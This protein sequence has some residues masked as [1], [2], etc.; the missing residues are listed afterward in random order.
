MMLRYSLDMEAEAAAVEAAVEAVLS[1]GH[2]TRDLAKPGEKALD[3]AEM[4]ALIVEE[5][6][7]TNR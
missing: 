3:T 7:V 6:S 4:T 5:I 2:R 1:A